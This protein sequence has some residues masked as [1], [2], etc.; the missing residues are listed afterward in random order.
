MAAVGIGGAVPELDQRQRISVWIAIVEKRLDA[1][2]VWPWVVLVRF[3]TLNEGAWSA[4]DV[5]TVMPKEL[6]SSVPALP[7]ASV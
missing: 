6:D 1:A 5:L 7:A 3:E 4:T 2:K